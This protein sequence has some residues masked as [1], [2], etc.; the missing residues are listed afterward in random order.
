LNIFRVIFETNLYYQIRVT[1]EYNKTTA[2]FSSSSIFNSEVMCANALL[3]DD[4]TMSYCIL[5]KPIGIWRIEQKEKS[6]LWHLLRI[7]LAENRKQEDEKKN[8]VFTEFRTT[9]D[10][11]FNGKTGTQTSMF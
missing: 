2:R 11:P 3:E 6:K 7:S 5:F 4:F 8:K 9:T 10:S 1:F